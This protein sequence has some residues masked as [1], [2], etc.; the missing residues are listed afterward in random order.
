[1][2]LTAE[3]LHTV[4]ANDTTGKSDCRDICMSSV[5]AQLKL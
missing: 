3:S 2:P 4:P 1:L 5:T